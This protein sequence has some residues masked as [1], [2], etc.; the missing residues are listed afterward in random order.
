MPGLERALGTT[1]LARGL[2]L[3]SEQAGYVLET[4]L[5][6]NRPI[7][8]VLMKKSEYPEL[9]YS[10]WRETKTTLHL[11][12]QIVGKTKLSLNP[13]LNHW[14]NVPLYLTARGLTTSTVPYE[15]R[16]IEIYFDFISHKLIVHDSEGHEHSIGLEGISVADFY[17]GFFDILKSLEIKVSI[18]PKP[19]DPTKTGSETPYPDDTEHASYDRTFVSHFWLSMT[20]IEFV[21]KQFRGRFLGKCSPLHFFWHSF[22]LA[23]TRFSGKAVAVAEEADPVTKD[24]YSHEVISA[25][26]WPGDDTFEKPAFY[27]YVYPEPEGIG[28]TPLKPSEAWWQDMETSHMALYLYDDF[29]KADDPHKDLLQFLQSTYDAGA[30]LANWPR[31]EL[32]L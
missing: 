4:P 5:N 11:M 30:N 3:R 20:R 2:L 7:N 23:M 18:T 32:E 12:S 9:P 24:A 29:R 28:K 25:G 6:A 14:W 31:K 22:D 13:K 15:D 17:R 8:E 27:A 16:N 19:F 21:F 26:F 10:E 1:G